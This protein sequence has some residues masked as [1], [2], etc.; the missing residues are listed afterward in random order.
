MKLSLI[1]LLAATA[2]SSAAFAE[3]PPL[4][5]PHSGCVAEIPPLTPPH[6]A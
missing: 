2:F 1:A 3:I 5:P 4:T 6:A